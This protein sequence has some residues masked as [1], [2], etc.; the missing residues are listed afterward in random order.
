MVTKFQVTFP[1]E[2]GASFPIA[3]SNGRTL[4]I[5][6]RSDVRPTNFPT[7]ILTR[8]EWDDLRR[9]AGPY[10]AAYQPKRPVPDVDFEAEDGSLH[11]TAE[12]CLAH[13]LKAR[14]GVETLAE[15]ETKMKGMVQ[16]MN[17][18]A[19]LIPQDEVELDPTKTPATVTLDS[20]AKAHRGC[21]P[22]CGHTPQQHADFDR[23][24]LDGENHDPES[25]TVPDMTGVQDRQ[26]YYAGLSVG[27]G[28]RAAAKRQ[29]AKAAEPPTPTYAE[30][31]R[32][33]ASAL[34]QRGLKPA[35]AARHT[36]MTSQQCRAVVAAHPDMFREHAGKLFLNS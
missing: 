11:K 21:P 14:F 16:D 19:K 10:Q 30:A 4:P 12:A 20:S 5:R 27:Q 36:G 17:A 8:E 28:N 25:E 24:L 1:Q 6:A 31:R 26:A 22:N 7:R 15:V 13:E 9:P 23:G 3:A 33:L 2:P 29:A 34:S 35:E 32:L 18:M